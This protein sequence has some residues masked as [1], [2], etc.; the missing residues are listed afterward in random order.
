MTGSRE[1][2][3]RLLGH[4]RPHWKGFVLTLAATALAAATEP[5][6]PAL[7]KPLLDKGFGQ[8]EVYRVIQDVRAAGINVI[9]NYIFGL[10]EDDLD[11]A[12]VRVALLT[13]SL[14]AKER[15]RVLEGIA[16]GDVDLVVGTHAMIQDKVQ[17]SNLAL[18]VIEGLLGRHLVKAR[19]VAD[20]ASAARAVWMSI[21]LCNTFLLL[22]ACALTAF[23]ASQ[24]PA[25][26]RG[27]LTRAIGVE[28]EVV[29][30][31]DAFPLEP[32]DHY[33]LC[34][35]GLTDMVTEPDIAEVLA[36]L[37]GSPPVAAKHLVDL[38]NDRGGMDNVSVIVVSSCTSVRLGTEL[39]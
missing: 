23:F 10:P 28:A 20:D 13:G 32:E 6:F 22:A 25:A 18:T 38:A 4:V 19:L 39:G 26:L 29:P 9:G 31:V 7:M 3:L 21:H 27:L 15:R 5:L 34:S 11:G 1:L 2:Y 37:G 35:D 36:T 24:G 16:K 8:D 17:F 12:G 30:D 33:L 14:G